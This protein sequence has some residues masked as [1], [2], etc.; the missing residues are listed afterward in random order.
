MSKKFDKK[1][2]EIENWLDDMSDDLD[3]AGYSV[4]FHATRRQLD[5]AEEWY[6]FT[7]FPVG[8]VDSIATLCIMAKDYIGYE[9]MTEFM[10]TLSKY[11]AIK[12]NVLNGNI[13]PELVQTQHEQLCDEI[14]NTFYSGCPEDEDELLDDIEKSVAEIEQEVRDLFND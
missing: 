12:E 7:G 3:D 14:M 4:V 5:N 1:L 13:A 11:A 6:S 10:N 8:L 9:N 2:T